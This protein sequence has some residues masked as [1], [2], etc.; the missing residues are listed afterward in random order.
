ME[1]Y[2]PQLIISGIALV[3]LFLSK[4]LINHLIPKYGRLFHKSE[5]R[6]IHIKQIISVLL[7]II[8]IFI[9]AIIWGVELHNLLLGI[10]SVLAVMGVAFF[11]QWSIL[12]NITSGIIM[13]F[14]PPF[15][16]GDQIHIM[17]KDFPINA[18]IENIQTFYTH[19]RTEDDELIVLPNNIFLQK[20]VAIKQK[21]K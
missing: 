17:D 2:I 8:F 9:L 11:A 18:T 19:I 16:V 21:K 13:F 10:S 6:R 15:R 20:M 1:A 5:I 4:Y 7:N 14:T 12:S 3:I